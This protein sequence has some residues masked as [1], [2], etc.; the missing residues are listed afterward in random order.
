MVVGIVGGW[1]LTTRQERETQQ[2]PKT[3]RYVDERRRERV[4]LSS[5]FKVGRRS[6][7]FLQSKFQKTEYARLV[8]RLYTYCVFIVSSKAYSSVKKLSLTL[9]YET[10]NII[11][12]PNKESGHCLYLF[13]NSECLTRLDNPPTPNQMSR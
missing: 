13:R 7:L 4:R 2:R 8:R 12:K 10:F 3:A 5:G 11:L 9:Y 6:R 1:R